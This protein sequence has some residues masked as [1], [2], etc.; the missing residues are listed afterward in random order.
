MNKP[1]INGIDSVL[2]R[3]SNRSYEI[4]FLEVEN[5]INEKLENVA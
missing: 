2:S 5:F 1:K 4:A 3:L